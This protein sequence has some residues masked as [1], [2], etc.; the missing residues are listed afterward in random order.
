MAVMVVVVVV[1]VVHDRLFKRKQHHETREK[2]IG[3]NLEMEQFLLPNTTFKIY[4]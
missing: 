4:I 1:M 3:C 2:T